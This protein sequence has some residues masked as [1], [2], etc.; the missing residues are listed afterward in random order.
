MDP[1]ALN[2]NPQNT[3]ST[4]PLIDPLSPPNPFLPPL[5][6]TPESFSPPSP[7]TSEADIIPAPQDDIVISSEIPSSPT[8]EISQSQ[9]PELSAST[10]PT[11]EPMT[12]STPPGG[13][14]KV[15][16]TGLALILVGILIGVL[17]SSF[18]PLSPSVVPATP[19][20]T[21]EVTV[22]LYQSVISD[23]NGFSVQI[24]KDWVS[25][26]RTATTPY[27]FQYQAPDTSTFEVLVRDLPTGKTLTQYSVD[28]DNIAKTAFEGQPSKRVLSS[29][30]IVINGVSGIEREEEF[31][32]AGLLG[33]VIYLPG[34]T[35]VYALSFIPKDA[36]PGIS[37]E[38]YRAKQIIIDSFT[39]TE[40][41]NQANYSC[42]TTDWV[43]CM[44]S[45]DSSIRPQCEQSFLDWAK[46][47]CPGFKGAAL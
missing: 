40:G 32:A 3:N 47:N 7:T 14:V 41:N 12:K 29:Q 22:S 42:P 31:L 5:P 38:A 10:T 44:P 17:A 21:P 11:E 18:I 33:R 13:P 2:P 8:T 46:A 36:T 24:P 26:E 1:N 25:L 45:V 6:E 16:L 35:R 28:E 4:I 39:I 27:L 37:S 43:D 23:E 15:I 34:E 19:S 30:P 20:P 9:T